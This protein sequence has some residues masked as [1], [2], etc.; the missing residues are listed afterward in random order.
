MS[1]LDSRNFG[2]TFAPPKSG[3]LEIDDLSITFLQVYTS[4]PDH[5]GTLTWGITIVPRTNDGMYEYSF[6]TINEF[7][8]QFGVRRPFAQG[9]LVGD[10]L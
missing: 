4:S 3:T 8:D 2:V 1:T 7:L 10:G 6:I 5:G 9:P